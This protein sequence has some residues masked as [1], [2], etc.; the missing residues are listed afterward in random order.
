MVKTAAWVVL[1]VLWIAGSGPVRAEDQLL[2]ASGVRSHGSVQAQERPGPVDEAGSPDARLESQVA[3]PDIGAGEKTPTK[4]GAGTPMSRLLKFH[5]FL[6]SVMPF[7]EL[8][9][10]EREWWLSTTRATLRAFGTVNE[11]FDFKVGL[12]GRM[13]VGTKT[14]DYVPFM[15]WHVRDE[16]I[17]DDPL[18][19]R[20]GTGHYLVGEAEGD[21]YVQEAYGNISAGRLFLRL[22]RQKIETGVG[23]SYTPT[24]LLNRKNPLDP[25]YEPDGFDAARVGFKVSSQSDFQLLVVPRGVPA[26]LARLEK[27]AGTGKFALQFTSVARPRVNWNAMNTSAGLDRLYEGAL[28]ADFESDYRWNQ[29][30]GEL[31]REVQGTRVHGEAGVAFIQDRPG[32]DIP[33]EF[34]RNHLRILAGLERTFDS[35]LRLIFEYMRQG[36]GRAGGIP[37]DL[38][39]MMA[40]NVGETLAADRDNLYGELSDPVARK[41]ELKFK[42]LAVL[43][44]A[45]VFVNPWLNF[46]LRS[47]LRCSVSVY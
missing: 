45:A 44:H 20:P 41:T 46:D 17:P 24:D 18:S 28:V 37:I 22:G 2:R 26:Y 23:Y 27:R 29:V 11:H 13:L 40:F 16:L 35:S 31:V 12:V 38:N 47:N 1:L 32:S 14:I 4:D 19:E 8:R 3:A 42:S 36:D 9:E 25:T 10:K 34:I 6:D 15:P 7:E 33:P 43:N 39:D 21:L 30:S 5:G